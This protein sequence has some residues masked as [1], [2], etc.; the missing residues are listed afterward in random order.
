MKI[1]IDAIGAPYKSGGVEVWAREV[2]SEWVAQCPGDDVAILGDPRVFDDVDLGSSKLFAVNS[3][4]AL[5]RALLQLFYVPLLAK[6]LKPDSI[7]VINSV[8]SP[9]I[10]VKKTVIINHDWRHL[11]RP[12]EFSWVERLYR[13]LWIWSTRRSSR[14]VAISQKTADETV[15]YTGR[16]NV[17][18]VH[19]G[20]DH[21]KRA[22]S[23]ESLSPKLDSKKFFVAFG[24]HSNKRPEL[25]LSAFFAL[26]DATPGTDSW[27]LVILGARGRLKNYLHQF[28]EAHGKSEHVLFLDFVSPENYAWLITHALAVVV[29]STDEG[30]SIPVA[31]ARHA[32]TNV[33]V[34][35]SAGIGNVVHEN[36]QTVNDKPEEIARAFLAASQNP[37]IEQV[38]VSSW[39]DTVAALK[40]LVAKSSART[41]G[42]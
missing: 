7:L 3:S 39:T 34:S 25:A 16:R 14:V 4:S 18:I 29:L 38:A 5:R 1:L 36:L 37:R 30:Y 26:P 15:A 10:D 12:E 6:R 28:V 22:N 31:E 13:S 27:K 40:G 41:P 21:L 33:I 23:M 20:G 2:A 32:G 24:H 11:R 35:E 19:P 42:E 9:L 8:L 17:A